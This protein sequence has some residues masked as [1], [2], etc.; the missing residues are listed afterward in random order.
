MRNEKTVQTEIGAYASA[1]LR[2]YF[3]KGP[4]SVY[5]SISPPFVTIHFRGFMTPVEKV[6]LKQNETRRII[7][8]RD[9]LMNDIRGAVKKELWKIG[10]LKV[11]EIYADWNLE[12][13]TGLIIGVMD[14]STTPNAT[15][16]PDDSNEKKFREELIK[17]SIITEKQP[18]SSTSYWL[19][20][21]TVLVERFDILIPIEKELINDGFIE[22]LKLSKRH[23]EHRVLRE[24]PLEETLNRLIDE[25]FLCWDFSRN[26]GYVIFILEAKGA[27]TSSDK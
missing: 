24:L 22:E 20:D 10:R 4:T 2:D 7:E 26:V 21:R 18:K 13:Q 12:K 23:L 9:L 25:I 11:N 27:F 8:T 16:W 15:S 19:N 5:V 6:L 3:G 17:A 14:E 1:L